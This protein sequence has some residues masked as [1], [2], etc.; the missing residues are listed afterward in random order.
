MTSRA[1][2]GKRRLVTCTLGV[3]EE[4]GTA[5]VGSSLKISSKVKGLGHVT[6]LLLLYI[7]PKG[8]FMLT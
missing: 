1:G 7:Y 3:M 5:A 2:K 8:N 6:W 4:D